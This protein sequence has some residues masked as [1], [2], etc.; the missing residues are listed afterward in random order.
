MYNLPD[1][2]INQLLRRKDVIEKF[3]ND[4]YKRPLSQDQLFGNIIQTAYRLPVTEIYYVVIT[5][6]IITVLVTGS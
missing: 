1:E 2:D 6:P 5:V 3:S 4:P